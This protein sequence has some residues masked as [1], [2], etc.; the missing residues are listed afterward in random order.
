[1]NGWGAT[2]GNVLADF[3]LK[4]MTFGFDEPDSEGEA[5]ERWQDFEIYAADSWQLRSNL[6]ADIGVRYSVFKN[7]YNAD[8]RVA[9]FSPANFDPKLPAGC[10]GLLL[11]ESRLSACDQRGLPGGQPGPNR[12]LMNQD[13][14][15]IA[16]RLGLAWDVNGNGKTAVRAGFGR[17]F[18]RERMGPSLGLLG[19]P[20]YTKTQTGLR[21]LDSAKPPFDGAFDPIGGGSPGQGRD[22][23]F[24]TPSNWMWN[25][26][27]QR[28]LRKNTTLEV[29]YIGNH[30][31]NIP[32]VGDINQVGSGD[33]N[34]NGVADRLEYARAANPAL[35][36]F[37]AIAPSAI[38]YW[39]NTGSSIYHGLQSQL[40][41]RFGR[42]SQFE[43]SYTFSRLISNDPL[44]DSSAGLQAST[45][46]SDIERPDLDRGLAAIHRK[47]VANA[48]LVLAL[49][50]LADKTGVVKH[51]LGDWQLNLVGIYTSGAPLTVYSGNIPGGGTLWGTGDWPGGGEAGNQRPNRV[52]SE[53]CRADTSVK[54]QWLN[55]AAFTLN[56]YALGTVG[57]SGRGV[58]EGP[59]FATV[60][61]ALYKNVA[62]SRRVKAQLRFEV[63]NVLNRSNF[64]NVDTTMDLSAV[65]YNTGDAATASTISGSTVPLNFGQADRVRDA[66]QAQFGV[67]LSF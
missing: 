47:H 51:L 55:P 28:E 26:T 19:N 29:S 18:L 25:L 60:D 54:H 33:T 16:P 20:P 56:G 35:R 7:P 2:T 41:G 31:V 50:A 30:G 62:L 32:R 64:W 13:L 38:A 24:K 34:A 58:C 65:T 10:N 61:L 9:N 57:T 6:T 53:P 48:S 42:G 43:V 49:P 39:S 40:V 14:N 21:Y 4:D 59:D 15:N 36:P 22:V 45:A 46:I 66:R 11:P 23:A 37:G 3:L 44:N 8:D 63:F 52:V 1:V 5:R 67:K 12:S 17:F 27:V